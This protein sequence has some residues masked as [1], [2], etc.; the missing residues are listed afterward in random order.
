[1]WFYTLAG[2]FLILMINSEIKSG[3]SHPVI[4]HAKA[5]NKIHKYLR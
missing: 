1:M 4:H 3:V 5:N 2:H